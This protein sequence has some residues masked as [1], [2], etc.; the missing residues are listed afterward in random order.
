MTNNKH[1]S[2]VIKQWLERNQCSPESLAT[3]T[4][5]SHATILNLMGGL[6]RGSEPTLKKLAEVMGV[7]PDYLLRQCSR[8]RLRYYPFERKRKRERRKKGARS[9]KQPAPEGA[10]ARA[11]NKKNGNSNSRSLAKD[12][13]MLLKL[14]R[15]LPETKQKTTICDLIDAVVAD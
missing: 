6:S 14:Y 2:E 12:E 1:I 9:R 5:V 11:S 7:S 4:G 3:K 15:S 8:R 10:R 13:E